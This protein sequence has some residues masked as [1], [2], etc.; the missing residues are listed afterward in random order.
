MQQAESPSYL[1]EA[2]EE[3]RR[4]GLLSR[5]G[6]ASSGQERKCARVTGADPGPRRLPVLR[7]LWA[8]WHPLKTS[9]S[10]AVLISPPRPE[11]QVCEQGKD[12]G[13]GSQRCERVKP[14][15]TEGFALRQRPSS[16]SPGPAWGGYSSESCALRVSLLVPGQ[17]PLGPALRE[18]T[19]LVP[20]VW[21]VVGYGDVLCVH[22]RFLVDFF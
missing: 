4:C 9:G 10:A 2:Q 15:G 17:L 16:S 18:P 13:R 1:R 20:R 8:A 6:L 14:R 21:L 5:C 19:R 3:S 7:M 12:E 11:V 22:L